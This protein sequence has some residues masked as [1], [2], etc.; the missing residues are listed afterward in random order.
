ME[1]MSSG[2]CQDKTREAFRRIYIATKSHPDGGFVNPKDRLHPR[3]HCPHW[4][5]SVTGMID[6]KAIECLDF[7]GTPAL[8]SG[9]SSFWSGKDK[10]A[11]VRIEL[12]CDFRGRT[13]YFSGPHVRAIE[14][15]VLAQFKFLQI[16]KPF[17]WERVLGDGAY[18]GAGPN[19]IAPFP[20]NLTGS[21]CAEWGDTITHYRS[22]VEMSFGRLW[23]H[24]LFRNIY[25]GHSMDFL[26]QIFH[27]AIHLDNVW[28]IL[29]HWHHEYPLPPSVG[30]LHRPP[31]WQGRPQPPSAPPHP[32]PRRG[33]RL[34][35][36]SAAI[37]ARSRHADRDPQ[38]RDRRTDPDRISADPIHYSPI[39]P[40]RLAENSPR[41]H[42]IERGPTRH[43]RRLGCGIVRPANPPCLQ[44][45]TNVEL[46]RA[47]RDPRVP[48]G[49]VG[50]L[51]PGTSV[52]NCLALPGFPATNPPPLCFE[53]AAAAAAAAPA[54]GV[55]EYFPR[56]SVIRPP[57]PSPKAAA[58]AAARLAGESTD[59]RFP[60]IPGTLLDPTPLASPAAAAA[61]AAAAPAAAAF[62]GFPAFPGSPA[63]PT[64]T[65]GSGATAGS[66]AAAAAR[67]GA[68]GDHSPSS[69]SS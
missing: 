26:E 25:L 48:P 21:S 17:D 42:L 63:F 3:N 6:M 31:E 12:A 56:F 54:G 43:G 64:R 2:V 68:G 61:A 29:R 44:K 8:Q 55:H 41:T 57:P 51:A 16:L 11:C 20:D 62:P 28:N 34:T 23:R 35:V 53:K 14:D 7:D 65:Q 4:K 46:G 22:R 19:F 39:P 1:Y 5:H 52:V 30:W 40:T 32:P 15:T 33:A 13:F 9:A 60:G 10:M 47:A 59:I 45:E 69:A 38:R 37:A 49:A 24:A 50:G 58:A 27:M 18:L 66:P 67:A 36:R